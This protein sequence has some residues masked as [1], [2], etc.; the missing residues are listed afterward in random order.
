MRGWGGGGGGGRHC[1]QGGRDFADHFTMMVPPPSRVDRGRFCT[2]LAT[3]QACRVP[4]LQAECGGNPVRSNARADKWPCCQVLIVLCHA[5]PCC[6]RRVAL[7][8]LLVQ[9]RLV[10][11]L[12]QD[13]WKVW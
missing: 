6:V 9:E 2:G 4:V 3:L 13:K 5:V 1:N 8:E 7:N 11:P 10:G 12:P